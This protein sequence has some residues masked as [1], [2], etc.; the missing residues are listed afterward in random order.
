MNELSANNLN[1]ND[2]IALWY[3]KY[4]R[5]VNLGGQNAKFANQIIHRTLERRYSDNSYLR[6]LE[7]GI[8][9]GEHIPYV[10]ETWENG[11]KY[12]GIDLRKPPSHIL[13][14]FS[15]RDIQFSKQNV[16]DLSFKSNYFDRVIVTCVL[17]HTNNPVNAMQEIRRVTKVGGTID[18]LLPNDPGLMYRT[19]AFFSS[20]IKAKKLKV[21]PLYKI[22][23]AVE[24]KN[25]YLSLI[26]LLKSIFCNDYLKFTFFPLRLKSYSL[27]IFTFIHVTKK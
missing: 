15:K 20:G 18:I 16:E 25:H 13:K 17:H 24:H 19:L 12:V 5:L 4:Y 23:K 26:S 14:Y 11:G 1:P 2:S 10:S 3:E 6:I 22:V 27:N 21:Y 9:E 7:V 8:N